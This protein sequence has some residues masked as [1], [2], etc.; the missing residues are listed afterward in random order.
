VRTFNNPHGNDNAQF[1]AGVAIS[2]DKIAIGAPGNDIA[3]T[4][5]GAIYVFNINTG[6]LVRTFTDP[7]AGSSDNYGFGSRID[8]DGDLLIV[9]KPY[10]NPGGLDNAGRVYVFNVAT[11]TL[12]RT[13]ANPTPAAEDFFGYS[14][15]I[16]GSDV[17]I[18]GY[19]NVGPGPKYGAV[20]RGTC[21]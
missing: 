19:G 16:S 21:N 20:Y 4:N 5:K 11:G 10:D 13:I 8:F 18:G 15:G 14:V 1:G 17:L 2:G 7:N 9:G 12:Q 3:G 6:A